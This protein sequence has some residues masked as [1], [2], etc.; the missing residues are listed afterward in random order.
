MKLIRITNGASRV[1]PSSS[2]PLPDSGRTSWSSASAVSTI[3]TQSPEPNIAEQ[4][5]QK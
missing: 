3:D 4:V 5:A 2:K 1:G